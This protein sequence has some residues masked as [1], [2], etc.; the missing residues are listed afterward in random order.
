MRRNVVVVTGGALFASIL[1]LWVLHSIF[2]IQSLKTPQAELHF[3]VP[4]TS[5]NEHLCKLMLSAAI[6][7]Y[8]TPVI[9][10]WGA[11]ED[12]KNPNAG[13]IQKVGTLLGYLDDLAN[14]G[15]KDDL[16][17]IVDGFDI[18]FQLPAEVLL[19]RY[20][21]SNAAAQK[22]INSQIGTINAH[23]YNIKQTVIFGQDK[24]CW[25]SYPWGQNWQGCWLAPESTYP[26][27]AFGPGTDTE[28]NPFEA[29][30]VRARWLNSGT[31]MGPVGDMRDVFQA[32]LAN[33]AKNHT[34]D[35]DQ[36]YFANV[37]A[38][39]EYSRR[40]LQSEPFTKKEREDKNLRWPKIAEDQEPELHIGLD[41]QGLMWQV[42][43]FFRPSVT[44]MTFDGEPTHARSSSTRKTSFVR[45][46]YLD[47]TL[48]E[49]LATSR[50]PFAAVL[51]QLESHG[52]SG[53]AT[54]LPTDLTWRDLKLGINA[55]SNNIFPMLHYTG[56]KWFRDDW[57]PRMWYYPY[58]EPLLKAAVSLDRAP[59]S[60]QAIGGRMWWPAEMGITT[61][62][63]GDEKGGAMSD[64]GTWLP[65]KDMCGAYEKL[66]WKKP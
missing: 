61:G 35:S 64:K 57:W 53:K 39:Q 17:L 45:D 10:N 28:K 31:V 11:P 3:L 44:W 2:N 43:G 30:N 37:W 8:P 65:W 27:F 46:P 48:P 55:I 12:P 66:L 51:E 60:K 54:D 13:H 14:A 1:G 49:D 18:H 29:F 4:A 34:T 42:L 59:I 5:S 41:Y 15:K 6:L 9:I 26:K 36:Y 33:I 16:V 32:A 52:K 40:L 22:R 23:G 56:P 20:F 63:K 19:K 47:R 38:E 24:A 7:R 62:K 25:P 50:P 58:A 21:E